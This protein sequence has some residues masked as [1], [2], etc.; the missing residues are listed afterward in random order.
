MYTGCSKGQRPVLFVASSVDAMSEVQ[1]TV[2][3]YR[4]A[5]PPTFQFIQIYKYF[6]ALRPEK[7]ED[8]NLH[9]LCSYRRSPKTLQ[10]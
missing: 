10:V 5:A 8:R 7:Q 1:R 6:A 4:C 2:R 3:Y 9:D